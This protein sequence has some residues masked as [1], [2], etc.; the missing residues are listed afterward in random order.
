MNIRRKCDIYQKDGEQTLKTLR[1]SAFPDI[2]DWTTIDWKDMFKR[3]D[4]LQK[5]L[6]HA[7]SENDFRK[8][9]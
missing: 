4:K 2:T 6:Y 8:F 1:K 3:V 9:Q 7:T 5:Q